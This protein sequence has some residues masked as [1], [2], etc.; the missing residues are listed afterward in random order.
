MCGHNVVQLCF[1]FVVLRGGRLTKKHWDTIDKIEQMFILIPLGI[2]GICFSSYIGYF[3]VPFGVIG[4][5]G[6]GRQKTCWRPSN[7]GRL[8]GGLGEHCGA[9]WA[10][11]G[12]F[13]VL[14]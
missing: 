2:L 12:S 8:L 6:A 7:L 9:I 13:V 14:L 11:C 10:S 4:V 5:L 1:I 3:L